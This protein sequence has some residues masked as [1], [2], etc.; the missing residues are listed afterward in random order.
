LALYTSVIQNV[1]TQRG[2]TFIDLLNALPGVAGEPLT[3][4]GIHLTPHG[5]RVIATTLE[6]KLG[7]APRGWGINIDAAGGNLG[8]TGIDIKNVEHTSNHVSFSAIAGMLPAPSPWL[9]EEIPVL[10]IRNLAPGKY[11]LN[12]DQT[13]VAVAT[14]D[15]FARG[16]PITGGP[17]DRQTES[18][19]KLII[20][21]NFDFFN[22]W[23][24]QNDT[25]IFGYRNHEQGRNAVEIP[26][27]EQLLP[28]KE[29]EIAKLRVPAPHA[30]VLAKERTN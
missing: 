30:Y 20:E 8:A 3:S 22:Y 28:T 19:R 27:F 7:Y 9:R 16:V 4:D 25:Y 10:Q 2:L 17:D 23:R 12:I 11:S 13:D 29:A 24:S 26:K 14:A 18:L 5:Y 1:A 21:K 6:R 15:E